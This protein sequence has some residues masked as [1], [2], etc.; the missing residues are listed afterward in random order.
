MIKSDGAMSA[1]YDLPKNA[2]TLNDIMEWKGD[3]HWLG[4]SVQLVNIF[5]AA[6]RW[7]T[8]DGTDKPY[9]ARK[10]LYSAARLLMKH[11]GKE[12]LNKTLRDMLD[13]EQFR[14]DHMV[15]VP[16]TAIEDWQ[17]KAILA[18]FQLVNPFDP[19]CGIATKVD[20]VADSPGTTQ[21]GWLRP[22]DWR[23]L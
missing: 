11:A 14:P 6:W 2:K 3:T 7:G 22:K 15:P 19:K 9:D 23:H 8:K 12:A 17:K 10:L 4:D 16:D 5:K 13:D 18:G 1:Y 21:S 20:T